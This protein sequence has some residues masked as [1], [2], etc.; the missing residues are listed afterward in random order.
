LRTVDPQVAA[1]DVAGL[2]AV[3]D[4]QTAVVGLQQKRVEDVLRLELRERLEQVRALT[5]PVAHRRARQL[6]PE[7]RVALEL[8][9]QRKMIPEPMHDSSA[10]SGHA[11]RS[12][13]TSMTRGVL[14]RSSGSSRRRGFFRLSSS[15]DSLDSAPASPDSASVRPREG[16]TENGRHSPGLAM[17]GVA[18]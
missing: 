14:G 3:E 10:C 4:L 18:K 9:V 5:D 17:C 11:R 2:R 7:P 6:H 13:G 16:A 8:T 1:L 15:V 12:S